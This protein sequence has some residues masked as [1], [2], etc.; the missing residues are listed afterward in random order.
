M[1]I[2]TVSTSTSGQQDREKNSWTVQFAIVRIDHITE[3]IE[4]EK[5]AVEMQALRGKHR[6]LVGGPDS[7]VAPR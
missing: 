4:A 7:K 1:S 2:A 6:K 5:P 3:S